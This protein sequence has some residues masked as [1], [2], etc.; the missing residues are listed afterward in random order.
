M[1]LTGT[2]IGQRGLS[3]E[4]RARL[5]ETRAAQV[6][7]GGYGFGERV[8][9]LIGPN[10][11][12]ETVA[13]IRHVVR[14][15]NPKGF[16]Q[17]ARFLASNTYTPDFAARLTM[18]VLLVQG[19]ADRVT[20]LETNAAVLA[21]ALPHAQLRVLPDIGHLPEVESWETVNEL[22]RGFFQTN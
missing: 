9:A 6:A 21:R 2:A 4:D 20:P 3:P 11:P 7:S 15:T 18:P 13:L 5:L 8:A 12:A 10:A 17:A 16:M 22:A 1:M 14:A 19:E